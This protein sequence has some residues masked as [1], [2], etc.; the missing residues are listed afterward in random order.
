[1]RVRKE[2]E[3]GLI[4]ERLTTSDPEDAGHAV[5]THTFRSSIPC[6]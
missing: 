4:A 1:M 2:W 3:P 6:R 5:G